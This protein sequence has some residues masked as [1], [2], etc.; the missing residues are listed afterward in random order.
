M[1]SKREQVMQALYAALVGLQS[2]TVRVYRNMDK[3]QKMADGGIIVLRDGESGE[4]DVMLS[5]LTYIYE[6]IASLEAIV[7]HADAD[8]RTAMLDSLLAAIGSVINANRT[9]DDTAEWTEARAP[10]FDEE[11]TEGAATVRIA[12]VPVLIRF[13]TSDPLN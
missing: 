9:L 2:P 12:R 10:D 8:Q 1:S 3:P 5:P 13:F 6:H 11:P 4:P 7:Q